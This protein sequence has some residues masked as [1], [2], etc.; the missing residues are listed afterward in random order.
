MAQAIR[1]MYRLITTSH[2]LTPW[3]LCT[4]IAATTRTRTVKSR[5]R[6]KRKKCAS[7]LDQHSELNKLDQLIQPSSSRKLAH[8]MTRKERK[9]KRS[10]SPSTEEI[11]TQPT[12]TTWEPG[13]HQRNNN[14]DQNKLTRHLQLQRSRSNLRRQTRQKKKNDRRSR[15]IRRS[16]RKPSES[17]RMHRGTDPQ[18][19]KI[20]GVR[21][22][23]E[24]DYRSTGNTPMQ[25]PIGRSS[26]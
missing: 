24:K 23:T 20:G 14:G 11:P 10:K 1:S 17:S 21:C 5:W 8:G 4:Q 16:R 2:Q 3:V 12:D 22:L 6:M 19:E 18:T 26:N 9:G 25:G 7:M 13:M 15:R